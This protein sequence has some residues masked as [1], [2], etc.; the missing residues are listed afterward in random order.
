MTNGGDIKSEI[1]GE[2]ICFGPFIDKRRVWLENVGQD[3]AVR[4]MLFTIS[5]MTPF[6][7]FLF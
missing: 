5:S 7:C 1:T 4:L 2:K 3:N 6:L